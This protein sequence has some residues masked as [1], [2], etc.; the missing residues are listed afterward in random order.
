[1]KGKFHLIKVASKIHG[2][3][4][5]V[6]KGRLGSRF[7]KIEFLMLTTVGRKSGRARCVPLA[8]THYGKGYLL[9]ASFGGN[10]VDPAWLKNIRN[11]PEVQI[12]VGPMTLQARASII[13]ADE[14]QYEKMWKRAVA[15]YLGFDNYRKATS[16]QIPIVVVTVA[17]GA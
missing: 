1:M 5:R 15:T 14:T 10:S 12:R 4:Y 7:G 8:A 13:E 17:E 2:A 6:S 3:F 11:N 9:V 16:R